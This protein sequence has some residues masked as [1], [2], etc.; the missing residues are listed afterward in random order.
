[1]KACTKI[2]EELGCTRANIGQTVK[3]ALVKIYKE[4]SKQK[5]A[6]SPY[7]KFELMVN[8]LELTEQEEISTLYKDLPMWIKEEIKNDTIKNPP[9]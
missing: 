2:S 5:I 3:R 8:I 1:M 7:E 4:I 9:L 6:Y